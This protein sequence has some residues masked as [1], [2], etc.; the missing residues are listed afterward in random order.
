MIM[1]GC[2]ALSFGKVY[3]FRHCK[4]PVQHYNKHSSLLFFR[5][6][7]ITTSVS[8][9]CQDIFTLQSSHTADMSVHA[10]SDEDLYL[11]RGG[12]QQEGGKEGWRR[13]NDKRHV[14]HP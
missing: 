4:T 13:L 1:Q 8:H 14:Q 11:Y 2:R 12:G 10:K 3:L 5:Q 6:S 9:P 7:W